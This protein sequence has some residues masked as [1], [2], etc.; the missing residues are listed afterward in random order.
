MNENADNKQIENILRKAHLPEP[1]PELKERIT[2]EA[3]K[4][5]IQTSSELPW[6]V[7]V[8][9]LIVS[10][11]A[12]VLIIWL[13]NSSSDYLMVRWQSSGSKI[14]NQQRSDFEELTEIPYSPL[15]R[16]L[17]SAGRRPSVTDA[18]VLLNYAETVRNFLS[19]SQQNGSSKPS[20][21]AEGRSILLPKQSGLNSYS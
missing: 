9:R 13:T 17:V 7:P 20:T 2:G 8:R 19:E 11:A 18:S 10:A 3:K 1:S 21:P 5:W 4:T 15:A 12:A 6:Q 16:H 14:A